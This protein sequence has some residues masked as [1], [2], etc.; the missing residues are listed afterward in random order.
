MKTAGSRQAIG[1]DAGGT[2]IKAGVVTATGG[3]ARVNRMT[4]MPTPFGRNKVLDAIITV[5][6]RA[7]HGR[8]LPVGV[9]F[10]APFRNG[11]AINAPN[12]PCFRGVNVQKELAKR[13]LRCRVANDAVCALLAELQCGRR[14]GNL[15]LLTL[16]TGVGG[17]AFVDGKITP[18][19]PGHARLE[20]KRTLEELASAPALVREARKR[21][22]RVEDAKQLSAFETAGNR[23]ARAI[24]LQV[25]RRLARSIH[26][27]CNRLK[28][29]RVVLCGGLANWKKLVATVKREVEA[30]AF[31]GRKPKI[32]VSRVKHAGI[33]GAAL[34]QERF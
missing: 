21:G 8:T 20:G 24:M 31:A 14:D 4:I 15:L 10:P 12:V 17:A 26:G 7:S 30:M 11:K 6:K 3:K 13:G 33:V 34:L 32:G 23:K 19:E 28:P 18:L 22:L 16:G 29:E 27:N 1:V 9:G 5:A 2:T 25:A